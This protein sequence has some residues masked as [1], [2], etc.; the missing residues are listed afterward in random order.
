MLS[1]PR[2]AFSRSEERGRVGGYR[3]RYNIVN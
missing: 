1:G 2:C 3:G